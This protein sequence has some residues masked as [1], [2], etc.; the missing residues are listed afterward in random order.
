MTTETEKMAGHG[1][2]N[3]VMEQHRQSRVSTEAGEGTG[4][5]LA[6]AV[7]VLIIVLIIGFVIAFAF[8][9]HREEEARRLAQTETDAKPVVDIVT[10]RPTARAYPL[11][12]PGQTAGWYQSTIFARVD[13]YVGSW[14][15]DI[16]DRVKQGQV[17]ATVETPDLDQQLIAARAKVASSKAQ[18]QVAQSDVSFAKIT[19]ERWEGSSREA[20]SEQERAEKKADYDEAVARLAAA[21][22]QEKLDEAN[23]GRYAALEQF[24]DVRAPYD[25]VIT[26]R[27]VDIGDL[28]TAGSSSN[29]TSLYTM[30][31]T[32]VLRV[33]VDVPQKAAAETVEGLPADITSDQHPGVVFHGKVARASMS[34]DPQTRTERTEVDIPNPDLTL[35]PGMYVQV[36]FQ[37]HER[38]L[39]EVPASAILFRPAGLQVAVVDNDNKI[40]F[41]SVAVAKDNG[42]TVVLESGVKPGD[43][44]AINISSAIAPGEE[45]SVEAD[46]DNSNWPTVPGQGTAPGTTAAQ[47]SGEQAPAPT[48]TPI[49]APVR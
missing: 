24:K 41:R 13:G 15:A 37:L 8:R 14:S 29:T 27:K 4:H 1:N 39:P 25:G 30:A 32:R 18:V 10:A 45:V 5:L 19:Y 43:R 6:I 7:A 9:R 28:V 20:V 17:L 42:D 33:F 22:A 31:Q 35:V 38:A 2:G 46:K 26:G 47:G 40:D 21:T 12:L 23:V 16:G 3:P 11:E 34:M 36:T 48:Q 44:V 49:S